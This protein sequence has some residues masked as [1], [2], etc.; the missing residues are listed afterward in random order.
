MAGIDKTSF[1]DGP[2]VRKKNEN[3]KWVGYS[4]SRLLAFFSF[5]PLNILIIIIINTL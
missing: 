1:R 3:F 2:R 4:S 5:L